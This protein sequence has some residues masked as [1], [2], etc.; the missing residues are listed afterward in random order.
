MAVVEITKPQLFYTNNYVPIRGGLFSPEM[1]NVD[2]CVNFV[3]P[4]DGLLQDKC[5]GYFG[6]I[7]LVK[8]VPWFQ[9][10]KRIKS[11]LH[12]ICYKCSKLLVEEDA[13]T[14]R[15]L[16]SMDIGERMKSIQKMR[17]SVCP[18]CKSM[19]PKEIDEITSAEDILSA[20]HL[21]P[22][23]T[24]CSSSSSLSTTAATN[25]S[26]SP[27]SV[28]ALTLAL[29]KKDRKDR[30]MVL[31]V[32]YFNDQHRLVVDFEYIYG[33]LSRISPADAILLGFDM[34]FAKPRALGCKA[35][36]VSP[37]AVRPSVRPDSGQRSEDD[38]TSIYH[39]IN[40]ANEE[41]REMLAEYSTLSSSA[42]EIRREKVYM[43]YEKWSY[44]AFLVASLYTSK[45]PG[46]S[47]L[48]QRTGQ[49]FT[50]IKTRTDGKQGRFRANLNGKR[51]GFCMRTV[52]TGAPLNNAD[53]VTIPLEFAMGVTTPDTVT[54]GNIEFLQKLVD[55]GP[56]KYPGARHVK[57]KDEGFALKTIMAKGTDGV[58]R[59]KRLQPGDIVQRHLMDGDYILINRQPSLHKPAFQG[60]KVRIAKYGL[61]M[62]LPLPVVVTYN[63][64][65]DGDEMNGHVPQSSL[66]QAET[67]FPKGV[68]HHV[69]SPTNSAPIISP[70]QDSILGMYIMSEPGRTVSVR[71]AMSIVQH[72]LCNSYTELFRDPNAPNQLLPLTARI[73][74]RKLISLV[75]PRTFQFLMHTNA[76]KEEE[77]VV[78]IVDGQFVCGRL[79][80]TVM[81]AATRGII[82]RLYNDFGEF[83]CLSVMNQIHDIMREFMMTHSFSLSASDF[84]CK[85]DARRRID[86]LIE[87]TMKESHELIQQVY[88]REFKN[89]TLETAHDKF[90][91]EI[92]NILNRLNFKVGQA[93]ADT[94]DEKHNILTT[95][96]SESK[97]NL[98]N[99]VQM[100]AMF[101]QQNVEGMRVRMDRH[102]IVFPYFQKY[103]L[104]PEAR[105]F[106][107]RSYTQGMNPIQ[108]M[109]M[110]HGSRDLS[111]MSS[112]KTSRSGYAQRRMV[113]MFEGLV[114]VYDFTVRNGKVRI[115]QF[116]YGDNH[117]S[118]RKLESVSLE[119]V[120]KSNAQ[121]YKDFLN[122][123]DALKKRVS[124]TRYGSFMAR[125]MESV[126]F[127]QGVREEYL[128]ILCAVDRGNDRFVTQGPVAFGQLLTSYRGHDRSRQRTNQDSIDLFD[129][130]SAVLDGYASCFDKKKMGWVA[131]G[132][133][134]RACFLYYLNPLILAAKG[135]TAEEARTMV[136]SVQLTYLQSLESPG[137]CVGIVAGQ[138]CAAANTQSALDA[139]KKA[140]G[141]SKSSS[142]RV[143]GMARLEE[144]LLM[145]QDPASPYMTIYPSYINTADSTAHKS[146]VENL[147]VSLKHC[148]LHD[149]VRECSIVYAP[150][151][152][153][154]V[155]QIQERDAQDPFDDF[156]FHR[157]A[158]YSRHVRTTNGA[159]LQQHNLF[160]WVLRLVLDEDQ[161]YR[162]KV[163]VQ[164][165]VCILKRVYH[166]NIDC[167]YSTMTDAQLVMRVA[168]QN[169]FML[170][171]CGVNKK[172]AA[173]I[174]MTTV[175]ETLQSFQR[176]LLRGTVIKGVEGIL[177]VSPRDVTVWHRVNGDYRQVSTQVLETTGSNL[178]KVLS[179]PGV[180]AT[181]TYSNNVYEVYSVLGK[182]ACRSLLVQE[183]K[184]VMPSTNYTNIACAVDKILYLASP[185]AINRSGIRNDQVSM[186]TKASFETQTECM[187]Q[188]SRRASFN[189]IDSP[190]MSV[191]TAQRGSFGTNICTVR[192]DVTD[193]LITSMWSKIRETAERKM[194]KL[195]QEE[196]EEKE[197]REEANDK[198][199]IPMDD[200]DDDQE[201]NRKPP[202]VRSMIE[203]AFLNAA[204]DASSSSSSSSGMDIDMD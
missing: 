201:E 143:T 105:G 82:H 43:I 67:I 98:A 46:Y 137:S 194:R 31:H 185:C 181:R 111:V 127:L 30:N 91:I 37:P 76:K 83:T 174:S 204:I 195:R 161:M 117:V 183:M 180:D 149:L 5:P 40:R 157:Y 197:E 113:K 103:E 141:E 173:N 101:G 112:E 100:L 44:L 196:E 25:E 47:P 10:A 11:T 29:R 74:T 128:R 9:H 124:S 153:E 168:L 172:D 129:I 77:K 86:D 72:V 51:T 4:T 61:A 188:G 134:F 1:G 187:I 193:P 199:M 202:A 136:R 156:M 119:F 84:V 27:E 166:E 36:P 89:K 140:N 106:I 52:I 144:L 110:A 33:L 200:E 14:L 155:A 18:S 115:T 94:L 118:I 17:C 70:H 80:K 13:N 92:N 16:H 158:S 102:G 22:N 64:D 178:L 108:Q 133:L 170:K 34:N 49:Q 125:Q 69:L 145:K 50:S 68:A 42:I 162:H 88:R 19:Q 126:K 163:T 150:Y 66:A 189:E 93:I 96:N 28:A 7:E 164:E 65:F 8:P 54:F 120:T 87:E 179:T 55:N 109:F 26:I 2:P 191:L 147:R 39:S 107:R 78:Q 75:F 148:I 184:K 139:S 190:T 81:N 104:T 23:T 176:S 32:L 63:A 186:I 138:S 71:Q 123:P 203:T 130:Q 35:L 122:I 182:M 177:D 121:L 175:L 135:V 159:A 21:A 85:E 58:R 132:R 192:V 59:M 97:G 6:Y 171:R 24:S 12:L 131:P 62:Q 198:L 90:E 15:N 169:S 152:N 146:A 165:I 53:E 3:C 95:I 48:Q 73:D 116:A 151:S 114:L 38:Q 45:I 99:N 57:Y 20:C 41:L 167:V 60:N 154:M 79:K 56:N 142:Y 160:P